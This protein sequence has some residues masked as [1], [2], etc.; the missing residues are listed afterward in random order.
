MNSS[1]HD[2]ALRSNPGVAYLPRRRL[3]FGAAALALVILGGWL[4]R[5]WIRT[6]TFDDAYMFYRYALNIRHGLGISW[7][8]DG[9]PTYGMT[10]LPWV[11]VVLPFTVLPLADGHALQLASW[12]VGTVAIGTMAACV[13][14]HARSDWLRT[15]ALTFAAIA[16]PLSLNPVFAFHLTTGMDTVLSLLANAILVCGIVRYVERPAVSRAFIVGALTFAAVLT[17][18]D[19]G[20]CALGSAGLAWLAIPGSRRWR[21]LAGVAA[22]PL[23]LIGVELLACNWYFQVPLP[24]GFYAKSLH[25]YAGFQNGENAVEYAYMG[26]SCAVPF[27]AALGATL[28]RKQLPL[29]VAFLLPVVLTVGYL[30]TVRQVMGFGGRYYVPF[31]PY[32]IVPALLSVD[33]ALAEGARPVRRI[34][35]A[36]AISAAIFLALRPMELGWE[37]QYRARVMPAPI[38]VPELPTKARDPLPVYSWIRQPGISTIVAGLPR[39]AVVAASEVGYLAAI[40]PQATIID[41]VGLN[42]TRIGVHGFSMDDLLARAPDL[43]WLPQEHYTGLLAV[44]FGDPRL[45]EQYIVIAHAFNSGLAIRCGSPLREEIERGVRDTWPALY[46]S[47]RLEDYTA[48]RCTAYLPGTPPP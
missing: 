47:R 31:L 6:L 17:R 40:A 45:L 46:P 10:S 37:K 1:T 5:A 42:D 15:P 41:L 19:N 14:R 28:K 25:S 20:V 44:M 4:C 38:P 39:G 26:T 34:G 7:N 43:I 24:L 8:P 18:P 33:A 32:A 12:L 30:L 36:L 29:V 3:A 11:F 35:A 2:F 9:V 16:L 13:V 22:L 23:A 48:T 21:D 27:L